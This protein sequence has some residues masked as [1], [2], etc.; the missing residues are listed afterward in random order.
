MNLIII[1]FACWLDARTSSAAQETARSAPH[2]QRVD[3]VRLAAVCALLDLAIEEVLLDIAAVDVIS[4]SWRP[5]DP[6]HLVRRKPNLQVARARIRKPLVL[7]LPSLGSHILRE[8]FAAFMI[9]RKNY[10]KPT[11]DS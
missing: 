5:C 4:L 9:G 1:E 2:P 11:G 8:F 3:D 6:S 7:S 10:T